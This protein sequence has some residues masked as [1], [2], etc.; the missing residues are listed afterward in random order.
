MTFLI[1]IILYLTRKFFISLKLIINGFKFNEISQII[2]NYKI[3]QSI[4][5]E[6][7]IF[8]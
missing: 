4:S 5:F 6:N 3:A 8:F 1:P 2:I 7:I